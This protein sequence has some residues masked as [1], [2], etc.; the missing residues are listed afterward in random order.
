M[1]WW[2]RNVNGKMVSF[3]D[4][5][6]KLGREF[7]RKRNQIMLLAAKVWI[8]SNS[9]I[10]YAFSIGVLEMVVGSTDSSQNHYI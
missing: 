7:Q 8:L 4:Y 10:S 1:E 3:F 5:S 9:I 2:W 6:V